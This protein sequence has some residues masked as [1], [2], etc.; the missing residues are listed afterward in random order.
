M[1]RIAACFPH[2]A[3]DR[4][5]VFGKGDVDDKKLIF[6]IQERKQHPTPDLHYL[7]FDETSTTRTP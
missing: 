5:G 7:N 1:R 2:G 4:G 6:K 3:G